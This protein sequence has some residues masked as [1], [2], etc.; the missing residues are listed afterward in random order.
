VAWRDLSD[1][2]LRLTQLEERPWAKAQR[3][4]EPRTEP[5]QIKELE[6]MLLEA[7]Q[8]PSNGPALP[9]GPQPKDHSRRKLTPRR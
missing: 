5:D 2:I 4:I 1:V 9:R 8:T 6:R 3:P 7:G